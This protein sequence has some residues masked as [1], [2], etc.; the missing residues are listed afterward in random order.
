[1]PNHPIEEDMHMTITRNILAFSLVA[2]ACIGSMGIA[3]A[4]PVTPDN[5]QAVT[6]ITTQESISPGHSLYGLR[7]AFENLDESF[8][9]N[10]S[11]LL[12]KQV[13]H[14]D[15]RLAELKRELIENRTATAERVLELYRQK[16]NQ[17]ERSLG[18]FAQNGTD[19]I[20][21]ANDPALE[22]AR[23]MIAN[24]Q[25]VLENLLSEYP[26]NPGLGRAYN[27]SLELEHKFRDRIEQRI[28][29]RNNQGLDNDNSARIRVQAN[30][31]TGKTQPAQADHGGRAEMTGNWTL[32]ENEAGPWNHG[33]NTGQEQGMNQTLNG[34]SDRNP[35]QDFEQGSNKTASGQ[36]AGADKVTPNGQGNS[37]DIA[38]NSQNGQSGGDNAGRN[39]GNGNGNV[40]TPPNNQNK[41]AP[42]NQGNANPGTT[43]TT[44]NTGGQGQGTDQRTRN[45]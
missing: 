3:A 1:M 14:A 15:T 12:E 24:H 7:I 19:T 41:K 9:F 30:P 8:T 36:Q 29:T 18:Q 33:N 22:H 38:G 16:L 17:T 40:V 26:D 32:P 35:N 43:R 10:E 6:D 4:A 42:D 20:P 25:N 27:N 39:S 23:E 5:G 44:G 37:K 34:R 11:E 28:E 21:G 45:R 31:D 13:N 2:L